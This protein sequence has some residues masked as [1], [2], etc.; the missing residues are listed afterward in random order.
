MRE[1]KEVNQFDFDNNR[2]GYRQW[3]NGTCYSYNLGNFLGVDYD[4]V[5]NQLCYLI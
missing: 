3:S 5:V 4:N 1:F 2:N